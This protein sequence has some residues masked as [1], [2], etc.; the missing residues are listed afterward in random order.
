MV[1]MGNDAK[2]ADILHKGHKDS[3]DGAYLGIPH[4][5][6]GIGVNGTR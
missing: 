2:I 3:Q 1:N 5:N 4:R 6:I